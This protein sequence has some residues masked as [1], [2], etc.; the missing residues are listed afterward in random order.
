MLLSIR[1]FSIGY[2]K[3]TLLQDINLTDI[4]PGTLVAVLGPNGVGKSSWIKSL[5]GLNSYQGSAQLG[6][7]ELN[8]MNQAQRLQ[9][10]GYVPQ[11]LP[12]G[13]NLLAYEVV[14]SSASSAMSNKTRR[15]AKTQVEN[16][17][18]SLGIEHLAMKA[19]YQLS[20]GQ[21]QMISLAQA[22]V[23]Q[24]DLYLLDE[25]TSALDLKWQIQVL[26]AIKTEVHERQSIAL[27]ISHDI[28]LAIRHCDQVLLLGKGQLL[29]QGSAYETLTR[30]N[31]EQAYHVLARIE[32]CSK[33]NPLIIVDKAL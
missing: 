15:S 27:L 33:G 32:H 29:G 12:Q 11:I 8:Q 5:A 10:I 24:T 3:H 6:G 31:T 28:N 2:G 26:E 23:R 4:K 7:M 1:N 14:L 13:S 22:L 16:I 19:M 20:G 25:P 9:H 17:F 30:S 21:K 18:A